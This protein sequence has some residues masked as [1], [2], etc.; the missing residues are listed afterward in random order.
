MPSEEREAN[1]STSANYICTYYVKTFSRAHAY[2]VS[3][4]NTRQQPGNSLSV[5]VLSLTVKMD[6]SV[7]ICCNLLRLSCYSKLH[8][9]FTFICLENHDLLRKQNAMQTKI[10][11]RGL[12]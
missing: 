6:F 11:E 12:E 10:K 1:T 9:Y 8:F 4:H 7:F 5:Q 2:R 3:P